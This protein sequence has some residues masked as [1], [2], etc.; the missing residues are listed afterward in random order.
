VAFL[1]GSGWGKST[2]AG[3][4]HQRGH[5]LVADDFVAV[6]AAGELGQAPRVYPGF[7]QL[8]LWPEAAAV[9]GADAGGLRRLHPDFEKVAQRLTQGFAQAPLPLGR[10]YVLAEGDTIAIEPLDKPAAL[11]ELVRHSYAARALPRLD[12]AEHLRQCAGLL[13]HTA[14]F[15]LQRPRSLA[16]L[17]AVAEAI[18]RDTTAAATFG[19]GALA[20]TPGP[21][22]QT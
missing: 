6:P 20:G 21:Q 10:L 15:R 3:V 9:L 12:G 7:P 19:A 16:V 1:G 17:P 8:K 11:V 18:E 22:D 13:R 5:A 14:L 4:L 2:M